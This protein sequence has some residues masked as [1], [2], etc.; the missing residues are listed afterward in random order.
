MSK[1]ELKHIVPYL[2]SDLPCLVTGDEEEEVHTLK[3]VSEGIPYM[4]DSNG[5]T[6][7]FEVEDVFPILKPMSELTKD[8]LREA[9]FNYY[10]DYLTHENKGVEWTLRAPYNMIEYI[11]S[12]HYD[13]QDLIGKGL[14][15]NYNSVL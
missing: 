8:E 13:Y 4:S 15:V 2:L 11:A 10:I 6:Y 12:K 5:I 7:A 14:A 9:G 3:G 1:I